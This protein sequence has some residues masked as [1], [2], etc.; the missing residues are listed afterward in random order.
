VRLSGLGLV[1]TAPAVSGRRRL[2]SG[3][4]AYVDI[5]S[6]AGSAG[7]SAVEKR[8]LA[9][10]LTP[11]WTTKSTSINLDYERAATGTARKSRLGRAETTAK[12]AKG[13]RVRTRPQRAQ[14][15]ER[16]FVLT[17]SGLPRI[18]ATRK[19]GRRQHHVQAL[20]RSVTT[21]RW[22][23]ALPACCPT[24]PHVAASRPAPDPSCSC[25]GC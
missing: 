20:E 23:S 22:V 11:A 12:H 25:A 21:C 8:P 13:S 5:T 19:P 18:S 9:S 16:P 17:R 14:P 4:G 24:L 6:Q 3:A 7:G 15:D 2:E 1:R 10:A